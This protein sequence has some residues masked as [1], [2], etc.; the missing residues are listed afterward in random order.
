MQFS[1]RRRHLRNA[2][3][4]SSA[5]ESNHYKML[6]ISQYLRNTRKMHTV[7]HIPNNQILVKDLAFFKTAQSKDT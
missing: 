1:H 3:H 2:R 5:Y 4:F 6:C 7:L